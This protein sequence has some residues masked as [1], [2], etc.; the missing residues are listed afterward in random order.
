AFVN[1]VLC[2]ALDFDDTHPDSVT[3]VSVAVT[4]AALAAGEA[5]GADGSTVLAALVAGNEVS[6]RVGAAAGGLFHARGL[7]PSGVRGVFGAWAG[8]GGLESGSTSECLG[9]A[10]G[11]A[12][13][14]RELLARGAN[15]KRPHAGWAAQ[16][17][18]TA[19]RLGA[20]RATSPSSVF[21]GKGG[22]YATCL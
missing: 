2:H 22:F 18:I 8:A 13:G 1:G 19:V 4:P 10:R 12:S 7:H 14:R 6:T 15:T 20:R 21:K 11:T 3:H 9:S 5:A 17:G 16:P